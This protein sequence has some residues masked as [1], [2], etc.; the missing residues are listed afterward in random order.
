MAVG[1]GMQRNSPKASPK[2][3]T[4]NPV[5]TKKASIGTADLGDVS[6]T[7]DDLA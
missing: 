1:K 2:A 3:E 7:V 5:L 4:G 6:L